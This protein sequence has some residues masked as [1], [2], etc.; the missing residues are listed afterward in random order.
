MCW[1]HV[2]G[3]ALAAL[4]AG[5]GRA[6][7]P[8]GLAAG[9]R[10]AYRFILQDVS[11]QSD[12]PDQRADLYLPDEKP[13]LE[14]RPALVWM[15]GNHHDKADPREKNVCANLADA[16]YVCLSINYGSWPDSD[17]DEQHSP[18]I[19]QN[20]ANARSALRYLVS[21]QK[22]YGINPRRIA[23]GG[24][25]AGGWLALMTGFR[26]GR[27][28]VSAVIDFYSDI[29]PWIRSSVSAESPPVLIVQGKADPEVP[30]R[31]SIWL[32][33]ALAAKGVPHQLLLLEGVG[34]AFDLETWQKRPLPQDLRPVV[35]G[36]LK[37]HL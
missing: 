34:H 29:D 1:R 31:D 32:A 26:Q 10:T 23:I 16:G 27:G 7:A 37:Q 24:A 18:R 25:S 4:S 28:A 36:F 6:A 33:D 22:A 3:A 13:A 5:A 9:G 30:Y 17:A 12:E 21:H 14:L 8:G 20:L 19:L 11:Y 2:L 15:H 35:L